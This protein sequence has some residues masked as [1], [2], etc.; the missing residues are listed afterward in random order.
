MYFG[1]TMLIRKRKKRERE[2]EREREEKKKQ[3]EVA[4]LSKF[5][6]ASNSMIYI[7]D[8]LESHGDYINTNIAHKIRQ[9]TSLDIQFFFNITAWT[10]HL[11]LLQMQVRLLL[12]SHLCHTLHGHSQKPLC[13]P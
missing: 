13:G 5:F 9:F 1:S 4:L 12:Q 8:H 6:D 11:V 2:R 7:L 3:R 10:H